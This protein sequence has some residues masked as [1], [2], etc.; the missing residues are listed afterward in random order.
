MPRSACLHP[1]HQDFAKGALQRNGFLT[2]GSLAG[3]LGLGTSTI[4]K[5]LNGKA[6]YIR[7]FEE[8]CDALGLDA[9]QMIRS[10]HPDAP[11][12]PDSPTPFLSYDNAWVGREELIAELSTALNSRRLLMILGLT[13]IG[14]TALAECL[15]AQRYAMYGRCMQRPYAPQH[16]QRANFENTEHDRDFASIALQWL[17]AW[18]ISLAPEERQPDKLCDRLLDYLACHDVLLLLDSLETLLVPGEEMGG[19]F[20]DAIWSKF[21]TGFFAANPMP[22]R[23]ILTSQEL[24]IEIARERYRQLWQRCVLTGLTQPEQVALFEK[25]D[26]DMSDESAEREVLLRLG[27]AY[28]GH[29]LVL[30]VIIGEIWES[31]QGN[32]EAYWHEVRNKIEEVEKNIAE[33]EAGQVKGEADEWKLHILTRKV[34][35]EVNRQRLQEVFVRLETQHPDAYLLLCAAAVYRIPVEVKGWTMQL[36]AFTTRLEGKPC[37]EERQDIAL[38]ELHYRFLVEEG[39]NDNKH[40][41]LGQHPLVRSAALE[42]FQ[43]FLEGVGSEVNDKPTHP[44]LQTQTRSNFADWDGGN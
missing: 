2:Q 19:T 28:R 30:R 5:F 25:L 38:E 1:D 9:S 39:I 4:N 3:H 37:G 23:I 7:I 6:V 40:R 16:F 41:T 34:R 43:A 15:I 13:G 20:A 29:P 32:V 31:F 42:R 22:S 33:A 26:L 18:G 8:I 24:P 21:F 11:T 17:E 36:S 12:T 10:Q 27:K 35:L 14:K 44:R